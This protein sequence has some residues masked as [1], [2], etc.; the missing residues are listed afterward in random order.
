MSTA[1][2]LFD[3]TRILGDLTGLQVPI[4]VH[5][6]GTCGV[7]F[8]LDENFAKER[9]SDKKSWSC[10]NGHSFSW[11]GLPEVEELRAQ[12][13]RDEQRLRAKQDLLDF[14]QRS[15]AATKGHLTR[16]KKR[17]VAGVCSVQGCKR[18]F[19]DLERHMAAKH[20]DYVGKP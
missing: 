3:G 20:P 12:V 2:K 15:H 10:P 17:A 14:E 13:K 19:A 9:R 1:T 11:R 16:Q 7:I 4:E 8:G 6:C 5:Q 18:H